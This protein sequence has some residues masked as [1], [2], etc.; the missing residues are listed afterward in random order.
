MAEKD[1]NEK[2]LEQIACFK[3]DFRI[4]ANF[5]V[6]KGENP[7]YVPDD[8]TDIEHVD[9]VMK[10]LSV[11]TGDDRYER[12]CNTREGKVRNMCEV[13]ERLER[14]GIE[15]GREEGVASFI[16]LCKEFSIPQR[17]TVMRIMKRFAISEKA[18][19]EKVNKYW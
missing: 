12:V 11:I 14:K 4:V 15:K 5:F 16:E 19:I 2:L 8:P 6:R 13:A 18:A 10:L 9:E 3:S 1:V 7:D 17:E